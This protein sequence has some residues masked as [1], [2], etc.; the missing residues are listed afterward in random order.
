MIARA[1]TPRPPQRVAF[2]LRFLTLVGCPRAQFTARRI[3][4]LAVMMAQVPRNAFRPN[5]DARAALLCAV[6]APLDI[7][8]VWLFTCLSDGV[9]LTDPGVRSARLEP[10]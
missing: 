7:V 9:L 5:V 3:V 4:W 2:R 10:P 8:F 1:S 6:L